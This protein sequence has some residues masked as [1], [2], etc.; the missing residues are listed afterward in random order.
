MK[1]YFGFLLIIFSK[2]VLEA[3][4]NQENMFGVKFTNGFS[5]TA[6]DS[7]FSLGIRLR[8]QNRIGCVLSETA[9]GKW[10]LTQSEFRVRRARLRFDGFVFNPKWTYAV[11][12]SFSR[13]DQDWD[14][15]GVPNVL[16]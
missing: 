4:S 3:Q 7:S 11:Q 14:N 15:G 10:E 12:L 16:R 13:A 2:R 1:Y 5:I 8:L 9:D 6:S